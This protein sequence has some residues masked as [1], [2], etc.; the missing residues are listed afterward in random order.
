MTRKTI[1]LVVSLITLM[2]IAAAF[3]FIRL[4][5]KPEET[6]P[7]PAVEEA[8]ILSD[9]TPG[10][11]RSVTVER[12][13]KKI[14]FYSSD[15]DNWM[16]SD[17]P[18]NF[19]FS[20]GRPAGVVRTLSQLQ[21]RNVVTGKA[22]EVRLIEYG[23]NP[24][25]A[26]I[27]FKD[28]EGGSLSVEVGRANPS[29]TGR[30]S[31]LSGSQTVVLLPSYTVG[32]AFK[33]VEDFRDMSLPAVNMEKLSYFEFRN[34][35]RIFS[36]VPRD[37]N[38][39]FTAMVSPFDIISPWRNHYAL[40]DQTFQKVL[41]E[42]SPLPSRVREFL[43]SSESENPLFGLE[44]NNADYLKLADEDGN[45]LNLIIGGEDGQGNRY[46]RFGDHDDS[47]FLLSDSDLAVLKTDPFRFM[48][49]FVFLGSIFQV[50]QVKVE[51]GTETWIMKRTERGEPED[52]DDD[53]FMANNL[54]VPKKEF[55]S[56]YQKF[57]SVMYEGEVVESTALKSPDVRIT[58]S[59][60]K[61][62]I[63]PRII[64]YWPYNETYYQVSI[65]SNP[66]EFLVGRYQVEEFIEDLAA[67]SEYGS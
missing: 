7:A 6:A 43:D 17:V 36:I 63:E 29:G 21:S 11:L 1:N 57:I 28:V 51:R 45:S 53:R 66:I 10:S 30:Y 9:F 14:H 52:T 62:E 49:K 64:R 48:S 61:P 46:V 42:E 19:R 2:V 67:L 5:E 31:R 56:V 22:D 13:D 33:S 47:L 60:V 50:S 37:G 55:T 26:L 34:K 15:G 25:E 44:N 24:P 40:D 39:N 20:K 12:S 4:K 59:H 3:L 16:I 18:E 54:E 32:A 35:G 58:I 27:T 23:L 38:D 65:D 8:V 41:G